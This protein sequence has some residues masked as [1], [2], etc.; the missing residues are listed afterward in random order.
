MNTCFS[1]ETYPCPRS[2]QNLEPYKIS[3]GSL[4]L[5]SRTFLNL[6]VTF[7]VLIEKCSPGEGIRKIIL[8]SQE[9][10]PMPILIPLLCESNKC[11]CFKDLVVRW[12]WLL[13]TLSRSVHAYQTT[14]FQGRRTWLPHSNHRHLHYCLTN[15]WRSS[16][17]L[18]S[19]L[20]DI[21][22]I[23]YI[24]NIPTARVLTWSSINVAD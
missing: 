24:G 13:S 4:T 8:F 12:S 17:I 21:I 18:T 16:R 1:D 10:V 5:Y 3:P 15:I 9:M 11:Q 23:N 2:I 22:L 14:M 6:V 19:A 20:Y 7:R